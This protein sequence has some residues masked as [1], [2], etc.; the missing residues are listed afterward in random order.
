MTRPISKKANDYLKTDN[1]DI[2]SL[3][4]KIQEITELSALVMPFIPDELRQYCQIANLINK[5][6]II[7]TANGS[8]AT[9]LRFQT[10]DLLRKFKQNPSLNCIQSIQYKVHP[11]FSA[12]APRQRPPKRQTVTPLTPETANMINEIAD[13][14]EDPKLREVMKR[15]A[16]R[17]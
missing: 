11:G 1:Q 2:K 9:Q 17:I 13:S 3:F 5:Q 8:V 15:I 10:A 7:I 14:L 4:A 16:K 12:T 6:L